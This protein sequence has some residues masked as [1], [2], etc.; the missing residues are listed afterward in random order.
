MSRLSIK[1][2][3]TLWITLLMTV[4][5]MIVLLLLLTTGERMVQSTSQ[6]RLIQAVDESSD[7]I[8]RDD[9]WPAGEDVDFFKDGV[10]ISVYDKDSTLLYGSLPAGFDATIE[11][12]PETIQTIKD[13][14]ATWHVRDISVELPHYGEVKVR[15]V[16]SD[17]G[18]DSVFRTLY[19]LAL[20]AVPLL[21][22]LSALG[23][24]LI[25]RR[26]FRP[27]RQISQTA[28]HISAG[29][30]LSQRIRLGA[31]KDEI[32]AL[33][34]TF[35]RMF[36]RLQAAF[37]NEQRF[38]ADASHE[39]R[40]PTTVIIA[41]CEYALENAQ[42]LEEAKG[43]LDTVLQQAQKMSGLISQLLTLARAD[44]GQQPLEP[45]LV[46]MSQLAEMVADEQREKA[47]ERNITLTAQIEPGLRLYGDETML[48][49][50]VM[51]L[52]ANG[53]AYGHPGGTVKLELYRAEGNITGRVTDDGIGIAP[54]DLDRIWERFYQVDPSRSHRAG[55]AGLG[56]AIVKWI[57][58]A[59]N[60]HIQV[61]SAPGR[62]SVFTFTLPASE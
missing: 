54:E 59:H 60:G 12:M 30:D 47:G 18:V 46:D 27:V 10:Y 61:Q 6:G 32:Y 35:D 4:L 9:D 3:V 37:E 38:T 2:R 29:Q 20:G 23:G 36:D 62:G 1:A 8:G 55:S 19:A 40:T 33:A 26:A 39:L 25:T 11:F 50:L 22:L 28:E 34:D 15:G 48:M 57:V 42:T 53:I 16:V 41:Q 21:V 17:A 56:L 31:G 7:E 52:L 43:A 13:N 49:M 14:G 45:E 51:N 24:Y 58:K 44:Q 5:A